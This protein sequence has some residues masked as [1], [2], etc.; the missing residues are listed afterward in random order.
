MKS[1]EMAR[2]ENVK[3]NSICEWLRQRGLSSNGGKGRLSP[4]DTLRRR[5]R[6]DAGLNDTEIAQIEGVHPTSVGIWRRQYGLPRIKRNLRGPLSAEQR[7]ARL[8]LYSLGYDDQRIGKEQKVGP[9]A[10]QRWRARL[11]LPVVLKGGIAGP[12]RHQRVTDRIR[13]AIGHQLPKDI[14]DD[15]AAD[16]YLDL[17]SGKISIDQIE[18]EARRYGNSV[19]ARFADKYGPRSIDE[20][21]GEEGFTLLDTM[22]DESASS[23]LEEMGA[24]VW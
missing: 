11:R 14:A 24:T 1:A 2:L 22:A 4:A 15:A 3:R 8:F 19:L 18:K 16:L 12:D 20:E 6:Y 21:I 10:I 9:G 23:W 7:A 17:C 13:R 5:A